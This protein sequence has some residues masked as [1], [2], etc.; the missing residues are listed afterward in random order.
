MPEVLIVEDNPINQRLLAFLL[1]RAGISH[2]ICA[3]GE[4]ALRILENQPFRVVLTDLML[5]GM[6]GRQLLQRIRAEGRW[7][8]L[9]VIAVTACAPGGA[10]LQA[11][12]E[13]FDSYIVKPYDRD[14]LIATVR[15]FLDR[16]PVPAAPS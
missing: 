6:S 12:T 13:G 14:Q 9:A 10:Q 4:E 11:I 5:P 2:A 3:S 15:R 1:T 16:A 8:A 7:T